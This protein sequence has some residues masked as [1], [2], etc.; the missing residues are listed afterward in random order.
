[1]SLFDENEYVAECSFRTEMI[2]ANISN[3]AKSGIWTMK[4][5]TKVAVKDMTDSHLLNAYRM[6]ER[7]NVM[8]MFTPWL[9]VFRK[10][11]D[12]RNLLK[13]DY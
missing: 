1:M 2:K 5:G 8:D 10:E 11:I 7:I 4:D 6:V 13:T 3:E 9:V 12:N